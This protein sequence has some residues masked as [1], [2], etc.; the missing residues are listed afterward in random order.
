[1]NWIEVILNFTAD[2]DGQRMEITYPVTVRRDQPLASQAQAEIDFWLAMRATRHGQ[3]WTGARFICAD[4][5]GPGGVWKSQPEWN[6]ET[7]GAL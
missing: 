1:M 6:Q 3:Q 4:Y 5:R 2:H 7:G